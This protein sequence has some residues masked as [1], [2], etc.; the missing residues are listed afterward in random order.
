MNATII[1]VAKQIGKVVVTVGLPAAASYLE[2]KTMETK[3]RKIAEEV[4]SASKKN[5]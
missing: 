1:K 2:N 4:L 3:M 5:S